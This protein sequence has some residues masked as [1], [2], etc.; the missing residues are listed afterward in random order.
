V[1]SLHIVVGAIWG[2]GGTKMWGWDNN[3]SCMCAEW[4]RVIRVGKWIID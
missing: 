4:V 3:I 2:G 1:G